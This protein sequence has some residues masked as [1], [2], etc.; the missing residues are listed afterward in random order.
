M[1]ASY[2]VKHN[3]H[4]IITGA[5]VQRKNRVTLVSKGQACEMQVVSKYSGFEHN[6]RDDFK[7]RVDDFLAKTKSAKPSEPAKAAD[8]PK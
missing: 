6:D 4:V 1:T 8:A 3:A 5:A 2:P 7:K